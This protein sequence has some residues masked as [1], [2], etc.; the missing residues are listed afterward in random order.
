[1][2]GLTRWWWV[3]HAPVVGVNGVIYGAEVGPRRLV[4]H[5]K[6]P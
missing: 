2:S 3:R 6:Q 1:M 5:A 4:K